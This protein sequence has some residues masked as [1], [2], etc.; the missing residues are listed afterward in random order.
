[1]LLDIADY[2]ETS[3]VANLCPRGHIRQLDCAMNLAHR[4]FMGF[5]GAAFD[6]R[7]DGTE[8]WWK[9]DGFNASDV[10]AVASLSMS[11]LLRPTIL[12]PL[13]TWF[14]NDIAASSTCVQGPLCQSHVRCALNQ[15]P[16]SADIRDTNAT[17]YL[18]YANRAWNLMNDP[19]KGIRQID[20][21]GDVAVNKLMSRKR[22]GLLCVVDDCTRT[23]VELRRRSL[24]NTAKCKDHWHEL[25]DEIT[26][27]SPNATNLIN[28][29]IMAIRGQASTPTWI[30]DLR[31]IDV[32]IWM[33]QMSGC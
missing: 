9:D 18:G 24:G 6:P 15:I 28:S 13:V 11:H 4:Y 22:P 27:A 31:I 16:A 30:S 2:F 19:A 29:G 20:R 17:S 33:S 7:I 25:H 10:F 8:P 5:T 32:V 1:M 23:R 3:P 21:V 14:Q 12:G 26:N